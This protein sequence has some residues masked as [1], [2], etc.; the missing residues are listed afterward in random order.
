MGHWN[1]M[2]AQTLLGQL[3][4]R[5]AILHME[6]KIVPSV[7]PLTVGPLQVPDSLPGKTMEET[8]AP[9]PRITR[10]QPPHLQPWIGGPTAL[11]MEDLIF[12]VIDR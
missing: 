1:V 8:T 3:W 10:S 5:A 11:G 6:Q 7:K 9:P 2:G 12:S 4:S